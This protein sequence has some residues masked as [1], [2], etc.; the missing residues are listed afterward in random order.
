MA[1]VSLPTGP[2]SPLYTFDTEGALSPWD[3]REW[4]LTDGSGS[5]A[6]GTVS[7]INTRRYHSLLNCA[8][9]PPVGRIN[10]LPRMGEILLLD[11]QESLHELSC[12]RFGGGEGGGVGRGGTV[13]PQGYRH[14]RSFACDTSTAVW[15]YHVNGVTVTKTL[16]LPPNS[17]SAQLTYELELDSG[18]WVELLLLPMMAIRDFHA[19]RRHAG[20]NMGVRHDQ[21]SVCVEADGR[22]VRVT[23]KGHETERL[24]FEP[25]PDWWYGHVYPVESERGQDDSEDLFRPGIFRITF[26][27][28][29]SVTLTIK[30]DPSP[31]P[32][33]ATFTPPKIPAHASATL[34]RLLNAAHS[35]LIRRNSPKG[36]AGTSVIAGFPWFADWG[37]DT[38]ISLPG[39]L[40]ETGHL[41]E[42]ESVLKTFASYVSEGMIPNKFD[43]YTNAPEYNTVD[44]SLWFIHAAHEFVKA[45]GAGG[46]RATFDQVL[47]PACRAIVSGYRNGT[48]FNIRMDPDD[49]LISQGDENTQLTWMDARC[50]GKSFTPR[51]GKPVEIN[52]LWYHALMLLGE[53]GLAERVKASFQSKFF[54]SPLRGLHD[55]IDGSGPGS[56]DSSVRPNQI[57][58]VSLPNSPLTA[59]QQ[60]AVVEVVRRELLT[61]YGL[62][63][64]SPSDP[65]YQPTYGGPQ[66]QRDQ[67]YHNGT[68]WPWL[69]GAYVDAYLRVNG[70]TREARE[71]ARRLLRPLVEHLESACIGSIS[72]IFEAQPPHRPVGAPAQAWSVAEVLRLAAR[73]GL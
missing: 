36:E 32:I 34:K 57:F 8:T 26:R 59:E 39:L 6:M 43:D 42:A 60:K 21:N 5:F 64:L 28:S 14:L 31:Y 11:G 41:D 62:R 66:R 53:T 63:T 45:A 54:I 44:A 33:G 17:G 24:E 58:A 22:A 70:D 25:G 65:G 48:R 27:R 69:M 12:C 3:T 72:E 73:I 19:L 49:G 2:F 40:L 56:R 50:D 52:A 67:A 68:I 16:H 37:R 29:A 15:T 71:E 20:W 10:T 13:H 4:L 46:A 30:M 38:F 55:T 7:G 23:A 9:Q 61:P 1:N 47:L 35:F 18:R 51:Q